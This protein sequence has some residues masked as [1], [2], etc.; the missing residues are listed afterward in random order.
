MT[1]PAS[2]EMV[3]LCLQVHLRGTSTKYTAPAFAAYIPRRKPKYFADVGQ[4]C[5]QTDGFIKGVDLYPP[6][7][8]STVLS[9]WCSSTVGVFSWVFCALCFKYTPGGSGKDVCDAARIALPLMLKVSQNVS[10]HLVVSTLLTGFK[11]T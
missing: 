9:V 6:L 7:P 2:G 10:R 11:K 8:S 3:R 4:R 5:F 1:P